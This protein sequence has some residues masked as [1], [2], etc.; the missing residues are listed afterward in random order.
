M[1]HAKMEVFIR[2]CTHCKRCFVL[3]RPIDD[4]S[5]HRHC[6]RPR[7][8]RRIHRHHLMTSQSRR[9]L[10]YFYW[11]TTSSTR[12]YRLAVMR[13]LTRST[14]FQPTSTIQRWQ[15]APK[16]PFSS[17]IPSSSCSSSSSSYHD[18]KRNTNKVLIV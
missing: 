12:W 2:F 4:P 15:L 6:H 10:H 9:R 17:R 13:S 5:H 7:T 16:Q 14:L 3:L 11:I 8:I 18:L 1:Q